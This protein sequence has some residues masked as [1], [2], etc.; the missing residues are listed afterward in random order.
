M[1]TWISSAEAAKIL[2]ENSNRTVSTDYVRLL[3]RNGKIASRIN[4]KN[5]SV[6]QVS[7]ED[8]EGY[9]VRSRTAKRVEVRVRD[10]RSGK[11]AGRPRKHE[12]ATSP[13]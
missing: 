13:E 6:I 9:T 2:S 11:P 7:R 8:C 12:P 10:K 5:E 4:P 3:A 1:T